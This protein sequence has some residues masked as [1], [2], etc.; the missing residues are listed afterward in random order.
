MSTNTS[1]SAP[2]LANGNQD[3]FAPVPTAH[4]QRPIIR[5]LF[6]ILFTPKFALVSGTE[7]HDCST[8][9]DTEWTTLNEDDLVFFFHIEAVSLSLIFFAV[10][11]E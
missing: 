3:V 7:I 1:S 6:F 5:V 10:N 4:S 2:K 8:D 9:T 11:D